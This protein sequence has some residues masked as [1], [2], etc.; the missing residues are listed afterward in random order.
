MFSLQHLKRLVSRRFMLGHNKIEICFVDVPVLQSGQ[1]NTFAAMCLNHAD[2][3]D[4]GP[5]Y[6]L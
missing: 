3:S 6:I 1:L 2:N 5:L 4:T